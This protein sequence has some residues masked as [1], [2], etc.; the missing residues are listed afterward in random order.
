MLESND[1]GTSLKALAGRGEAELAS[2]VRKIP[3]IHAVGDGHVCGVSNV[4]YSLE[5]GD[6]DAKHGK[7]ESLAQQAHLTDNW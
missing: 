7:W 2:H 1:L 5:G 3:H 4:N 6:V